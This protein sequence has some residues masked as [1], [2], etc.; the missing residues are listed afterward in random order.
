MFTTTQNTHIPK[1]PNPPWRRRG[2]L[3]ETGNIF[4]FLSFIFLLLCENNVSF[5]L[6]SCPPFLLLVP[7]CISRPPPP[8]LPSP[9]LPP[10][11]H[12]SISPS[13]SPSLTL[14]FLFLH[15]SSPCPSTPQT[16]PSSHGTLSFPPPLSLSLLEVL[17]CLPARCSLL[18]WSVRPSVRPSSLFTPLGSSLSLPLRC[19]PSICWLSGE[20]PS[21]KHATQPAA[22]PAVAMS[23][24]DHHT[25]AH[26]HTQAQAHAHA[27]AH[28][29]IHTHTHTGLVPYRVWPGLRLLR[30]GSTPCD[31]FYNGCG[32]QH[33]DLQVYP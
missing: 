22:V 28:T 17:P 18:P 1:N 2:S 4:C 15:P 16:A 21:P 12:V 10:T 24:V 19:S 11:L 26:A 23:R 9:H 31:L 27:H 6:L 33:S 3:W 32:L 30:D 13:I 25:H 5:L 7:L 14:H 20:P 8:L 29:H